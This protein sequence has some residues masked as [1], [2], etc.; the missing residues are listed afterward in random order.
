ME[1]C[2]DSSTQ[3]GE[4]EKCVILIWPRSGDT[5]ARYSGGGVFKEEATVAIVV[6]IVM[7]SQSTYY[8]MMTRP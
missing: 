3:C 5:T 7:T 2:R 4:S 6:P 1:M 8:L